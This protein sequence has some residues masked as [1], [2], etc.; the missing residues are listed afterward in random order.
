[1]KSSRVLDNLNRWM[2]NIL[3]V[4]LF[5]GL[6][7]LISGLLFTWGIE[8]GLDIGLYD[9]SNYLF[10]GVNIHQLG[11]PAPEWAPLYSIWY[12]ILSLYEPD[13]VNLYF[14]NFKLVTILPPL[15]CYIFLRANRVKILVSL[16]IAWLFLISRSNG[17]TWPKVS[18]FAL[19][20]MM[21]TF[22]AVSRTQ[23]RFGSIWFALIGSLSVSYVRPEYFIICIIMFVLLLRITAYGEKDRFRQNR[24]GL[25]TAGLAIFGALL[26][27]GIPWSKTRSIGAIGQHFSV[28]WVTWTESNMNPWTN[29]QTI[30]M[31]NFGKIETVQEMVLSNPTLFGQHIIYNV[32]NLFPAIWKQLLPISI[33]QENTIQIFLVAIVL[34]SLLTY[35][36]I[37]LICSARPNYLLLALMGLFLVPILLSVTVIY[38]RDHYLSICIAIVVFGIAVLIG[39]RSDTT[40]VSNVKPWQI[41]I[42]G[43][44]LILLTPNLVDQIGANQ[45]TLSTIRFIQSLQIVESVNILEAEGGYPIYLGDNFHRV[46]EFHKDREFSKF[47]DEQNI[48][49]IVASE[50]MKND[51]RYREDQEWHKFVTNF[52]AQGFSHFIIPNTGRDLYISTDLLLSKGQ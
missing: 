21:L 45:P 14:L 8:A 6:I 3:F 49:M 11:I 36:F 23:T 48:N 47:V 9:E 12:F 1:M 38:P 40:Q 26:L 2:H 32:K 15:L 24:A 43:L 29:W 16:L 18:H 20:L 7:L 41:A 28:N 50:R 10:R 4:D 22:I 17:F 35:Y 44:L 13:H 34:F 33:D 27:F 19:I 46:A 31:E 25:L 42:I 37:R 30:V 52:A 5:A 39:G 51:A